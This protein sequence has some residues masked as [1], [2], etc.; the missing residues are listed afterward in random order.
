[1]HVHI[2]VYPCTRIQW[3]VILWQ[4]NN[5]AA[6]VHT[7]MLKFKEYIKFTHRFS[8]Q[9]CLFCAF[10]FSR[11]TFSEFAAKHARDARFKAIEKMKDR[12]SIFSEFMTSLKKKEKENSKNRGE[13]VSMISLIVLI[14]TIDDRR[15]T[16]S[17]DEPD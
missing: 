7:T 3:E 1:M 11:T 17:R 6:H 2:H 8:D 10:L 13:K 14:S 15:G 16:K 12:E 9:L 5:E 4:Q